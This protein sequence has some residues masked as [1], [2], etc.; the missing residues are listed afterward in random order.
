MGSVRFMVVPQI[1]NPEALGE[2]VFNLPSAYLYSFNFFQIYAKHADRVEEV[3]LTMILDDMGGSLINGAYS[4]EQLRQ[5]TPLE[6]SCGLDN[7][8]N[9]FNDYHI[10][11]NLKSTDE[12][13][14]KQSLM[15]GQHPLKSMPIELMPDPLDFTFEDFQIS[16]QSELDCILSESQGKN[17]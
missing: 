10:L 2:Y 11:F 6:M 4:G 5:L 14:I 13:Y 16:L 8:Q 17:L 15:R 9:V 1:E 7:L 12:Y 3:D